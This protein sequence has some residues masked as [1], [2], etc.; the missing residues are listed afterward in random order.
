LENTVTEENK[1][2]VVTSFKGFD[3]QFRCRGFQYEVGATYEHNGNVS[4]C[5]S[6]FHACENPLDV[7]NY[8]GPAESK[9]AIVE[10]SGKLARHDDDSKIA[11][12]TIT[13][14]AELALG[15]FVKR[16]VQWV[17]EH[18]G[19]DAKEGGERVQSSSGYYAQLAASGDYAKLAASGDSAQLAASGDSAKLAASGY[20]AQLAASGD[21]AKLAASGDYA[22][23]AA[24]GY[25]AQLAASG[26]YAKLAASGDS[27]QLAASG[28]YAQ[29]AA[30]GY[31][32]QLAASGD[33]AKLAAAGK[34]SVIASSSYRG[35]AKGAEGTWIALAEFND[36]DKCVGFATGC[37]GADGLKADTWYRASGGKL[38]A[39]EQ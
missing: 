3:A 18:C 26:D 12:A 10:Q 21:Y 31:C 19:K 16:A 15:D 5:N 39:V 4:P 7:W 17:I 22:K 20:Y 34:D 29:L 8:Y 13:I 1:A 32:A 36:D 9:F 35:V 33:S 25:Y 27:A 37:I 6:G 28:D 30:S 24:S 38:V 23:L 11:S 2:E 14:K